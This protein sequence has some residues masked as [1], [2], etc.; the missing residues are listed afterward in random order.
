MDYLIGGLVGLIVGAV[1]HGAIIAWVERLRDLAEM[2]A[3]A[4]WDDLTRKPPS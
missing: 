2:K 3:R 1:C 4:K